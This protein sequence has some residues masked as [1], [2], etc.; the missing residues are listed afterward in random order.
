MA[1][2]IY[3]L[4]CWIAN[5][6][7]FWNESMTIIGVIF[8]YHLS[9]SGKKID[10]WVGIDSLTGEKQ[11]V[12]GVDVVDR[13]CPK[14]SRNTVY[15]GRTLYNIILYEASTGNKWNISFSEYATS[16]SSS[17][18]ENYGKACYYLPAVL[19]YALVNLC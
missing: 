2:V 5:T 15:F 6:K 17:A 3:L 7:N 8:F 12:L 9:F 1:D 11:L 4:F 14:P 13:K 16:T 10:S 19:Y 18:V